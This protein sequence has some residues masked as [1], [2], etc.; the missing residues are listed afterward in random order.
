M[1]K[2]QPER[3]SNPGR[4]GVSPTH[5]PLGHEQPLTTGD[6]S[7]KVIRRNRPKN[8]NAALDNLIIC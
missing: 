1:K 4:L 7:Y 5:V 2:R 3:D 6:Q 8:S